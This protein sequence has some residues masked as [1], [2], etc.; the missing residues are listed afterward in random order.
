MSSIYVRDEVKSFFVSDIPTETIVLDLTGEWS[1][2]EE[3]LRSNG[4][5]YDTPWVGLQFIGNDEVPISL[6][7]NNSKG[8]YRETGIVYIHVVEPASLT[9]GNAIVT[10]AE[11]IRKAFRGQRI[12]DMLIESV[13]PVNTERGG[14]LEFDGGYVS[15]SVI[16]SYQRDENL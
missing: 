10:R 13:S 6:T 2:F 4:V 9:S 8:C 14:T 5:N 12:G 11:T 15:G 3:Y 7:A 16:A 1:D